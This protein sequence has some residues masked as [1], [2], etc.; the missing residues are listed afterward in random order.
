M[1][2]TAP[3]WPLAASLALGVITALWVA[4]ES[5]RIRWIRPL[6]GLTFMV[7]V[8]AGL[9]E[10][11][12][13][14]VPTLSMLGRPTLGVIG[15]SISAG[16]D[17][18]ESTTWP[19]RLAERH[20]ITVRNH[21]LAGA[22]VHSAFSQVA[23]CGK[24]ET[25]ILLEIGGNDLLAGTSYHVFQTDLARLLNALHR[26]GRSVVMLELPLI[27]GRNQYNLIQRRLAAQYQVVLIPKRIWAGVLL[28]D[29]A[30]LDSV[31][32][33]PT[34]HDLMAA[35]IWATIRSAYRI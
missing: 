30:T 28:A 16:L 26:S 22:T 14:V 15:D 6:R 10:A 27:P 35:A 19:E 5:Q 32:L 1:V 25:L 9:V 4:G 29:G 23:N 21:A 3:P 34:G 18:H 11:S 17:D 31:H 7:G 20:Q 8:G 33:S 12:Y 2:V 13:Q 24:D